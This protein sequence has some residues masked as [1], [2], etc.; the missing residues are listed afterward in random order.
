MTLMQQVF[1]GKGNYPKVVESEKRLIDYVV[2]NE[3]AIGYASFENVNDNKNV[4][5][6]KVRQ[7]EER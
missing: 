2:K 6:I 3:N 7:G 4:N 1:L 5:I